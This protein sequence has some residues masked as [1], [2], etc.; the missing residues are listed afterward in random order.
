MP[1]ILSDSLRHAEPDPGTNA[2][3]GVSEQERVYFEVTNLY[4]EASF[5]SVLIVGPSSTQTCEVVQMP[6]DHTV[7]CLVPRGIGAGHVFWVQAVNAWAPPGTDTYEYPVRPVI[8]NLT[9][10]SGV[11][12][13][14]GIKDCPT[15]GWSSMT[16]RGTNFVNDSLAVMIGGVHCASVSFQ[17][18]TTITC[19]TPEGVG[20]NLPVVVKCGDT[21]SPAFTAFSYA[22]PSLTRIEC[23]G[24]TTI[25]NT[26]VNLDRSGANE[27]IIFGKNFGPKGANILMPEGLLTNPRHDAGNPHGILRGETP[28]NLG[29]PFHDRPVTVIN[30]AGQVSTN[31]IL[32]NYVEQ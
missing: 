16:V 7:S 26:V 15:A 28:A 10:S 1:I 18:A 5:L 31:S 24:A 22:P 20:T 17:N 30:A 32:V 23:P 25:G 14:P 9:C 12:D 6:T 13:P 11:A 4:W 2:L 3:V 21:V 27:L 19:F 29:A 8:T